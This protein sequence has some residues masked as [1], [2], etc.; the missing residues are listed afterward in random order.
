MGFTMHKRGQGMYARASA[1]LILGFTV[2][3]GCWEFYQSDLMQGLPQLFYMDKFG[4]SVKVTWGMLVAGLIFAA[5]LGVVVSLTFGF[6]TQFRWLKGLESKSTGF[7]EFLIDVEGELR[8]VAWPTRKQLVNSTS[9]VLL[10]TV[11]VAVFI[12]CVDQVLQ[13]VMWLAGIL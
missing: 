4:F 9:V 10:A 8:K 6:T 11:L 13:E 5:L 3:Y 12:F 1:A 7:V 2:L